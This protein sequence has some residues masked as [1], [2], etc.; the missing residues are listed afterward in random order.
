MIAVQEPYKPMYTNK[1]KFITLLTGGRGGGKSFEASTFIERL[2]FESGHKILYSRYTMTSAHI[3]VIPEFVE[4]IEMEGTQKYFNVTQRDIENLR[5]GSLIMFRGIKT[6][7]GNQTANLKSIQG[8]TT[9]VGD[10]MEEWVDE[11]SFD[12][13]M[14]SIRQKG[15]QNRIILIM[16]PS[17]V[18]HFIYKRYIENTQKIVE[19]DG[20]PVQISTH[21]NVLHIHTTY[22]DN[23]NHLGEQFIKDIKQMKIDNPKKYAHI[24]MGQWAELL[25]GVIFKF[26]VVEDIP[27]WVKKRWIGID[28]GY[29][30]DSTAIAEVAIEGNDLYIDEKCYKTEMLTKDIIAELKQFQGYKVISESADPR[31][32]QEIYNAGI[33]IHPVNK[34]AGSIE[35]GINKKLEYNIK[36]TSRSKNAIYEYQN[37]VWDKDKEGNKLNVPKQGDDHICDAVRYVILNEVIGR[38]KKNIDISGVFY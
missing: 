23:L 32:V 12:K 10:E 8:L 17:N 36:I 33:N 22:L 38:N 24:A 15:I 9:F 35:A 21:P 34:Y 4:K 1:D 3:S 14:F 28:F 6:S 2:S 31:I 20:V 26:E 19:F 11:D 27:V 16:N 37:L 25:E 29:S 7:S 13:L 18:N 5:S 30:H